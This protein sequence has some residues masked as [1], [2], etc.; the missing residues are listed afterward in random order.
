MLA[1]DKPPT[2]I[3]MAFRLCTTRRPDAEEAGV[4]LKRLATLKKE[5]TAAPKEAAELLLVGESAP[6]ERLDKVKHAAY[7]AL[8]LLILNLDET[9]SR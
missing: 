7:T 2:R 5:Y 3:E 8:C 1:S 6:D 9:L 4:L